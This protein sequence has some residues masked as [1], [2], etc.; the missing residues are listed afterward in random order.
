MNLTQKELY[1]LLQQM[2]VECSL[3]TLSHV[4]T[5]K[6]DFSAE[7]ARNVGTAISRIIA[8]REQS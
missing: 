1:D 6:R 2:G 7:M 5:G 8:Q 4:E 3:S